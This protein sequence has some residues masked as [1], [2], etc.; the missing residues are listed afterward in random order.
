MPWSSQETFEVRAIALGG[1]SVADRKNLVTV[2]CSL[3]TDEHTCPIKRACFICLLLRLAA[4]E[5]GSR[6]FTGEE[7]GEDRS[8]QH[9]QRV[10]LRAHT[11][12]LHSPLQHADGLA[13]EG[14]S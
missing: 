1:D 13:A 14:P 4:E 11:L 3:R 5:Q 7:L 12:G 9:L 10:A 6:Q 8:M 2:A